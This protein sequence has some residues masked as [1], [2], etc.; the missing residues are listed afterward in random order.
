[1][2]PSGVNLYIMSSM[3]AGVVEQVVIRKHIRDR[4]NQDRDDGSQEVVSATSKTGGKAKKKRAK[5]IIKLY[6]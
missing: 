3:A 4:E 2:G 6:R 5:P 1:K